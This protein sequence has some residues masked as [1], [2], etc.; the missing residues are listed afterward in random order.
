LQIS[1]VS[2]LVRDDQVDLEW[3]LAYVACYA[4]KP[5]LQ[6]TELLAMPH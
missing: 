3:W 2:T 5:N 1:I 6:L 4:I